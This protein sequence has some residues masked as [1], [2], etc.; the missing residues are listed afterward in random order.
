MDGSRRKQEETGKYGRLR[1]ATVS[2][3]GRESSER[4]LG[5]LVD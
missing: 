5:E 4:V 1:E 3:Y 2:N